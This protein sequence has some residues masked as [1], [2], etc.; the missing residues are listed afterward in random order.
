MKYIVLLF[1]GTYNDAL[2]IQFVT[3]R[4]NRGRSQ[5]IAQKNSSATSKEVH[6]RAYTLN[7]TAL[8]ASGHEMRTHYPADYA[9]VPR[10]IALQSSRF[11]DRQAYNY[12]WPTGA[13]AMQCERRAT[14]GR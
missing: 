9:L 3:T 10:Q 7:C 12:N 11:H 2:E 13:V 4:K 1:L 5:H 6:M 8:T 14:K